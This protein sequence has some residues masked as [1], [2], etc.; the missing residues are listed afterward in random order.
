MLD[1]GPHLRALRGARGHMTKHVAIVGARRRR[2]FAV[3]LNLAA[4][5]PMMENG[6]QNVG[7]GCG[8]D[9]VA[10]AAVFRLVSHG[11]TLSSIFVGSVSNGASTWMCRL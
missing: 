1:D 9:K 2:D 5:S 7:P 11:P 4:P 6:A 8:T 10:D 3:P